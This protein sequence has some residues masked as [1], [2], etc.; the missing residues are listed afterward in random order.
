MYIWSTH[1]VL[2]DIKLKCKELCKFTY[3]EGLELDVKQNTVFDI[4][5]IPLTTGQNVKQKQM[6]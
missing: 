4:K 1:L 6:S 3:C 2:I 5:Q